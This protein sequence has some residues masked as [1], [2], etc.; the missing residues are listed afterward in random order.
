LV[1]KVVTRPAPPDRPAPAREKSIYL[2]TEVLF[3][4]ET[5]PTLVTRLVTRHAPP[6]RPAPARGKRVYSYATV[7]DRN[8]HPPWSRD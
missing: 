1:T 2:F 7:T 8:K 6:D 5:T 4:I 3:R